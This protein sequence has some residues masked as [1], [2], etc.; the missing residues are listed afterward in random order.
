MGW[1]TENKYLGSKE[2]RSQATKE[3]PPANDESKIK[4]ARGKC[5]G[6]TVQS[7]TGPRVRRRLRGALLGQG[8]EGQCDPAGA[9]CCLWMRTELKGAEE[10]VLD[11]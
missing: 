3:Q 10:P 7:K 5:K 1:A 6:R 8:C 9:T 11:A 2:P 4:T